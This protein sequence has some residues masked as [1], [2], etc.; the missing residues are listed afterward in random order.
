MRSRPLLHDLHR[1]RWVA[2]VWVCEGSLLFSGETVL[3]VDEKRFPCTTTWPREPCHHMFVLNGLVLGR[4]GA[5]SVADKS[6]AFLGV[7]PFF[8]GELAQKAILHCNSYVVIGV[9]PVGI[10]RV[11]LEVIVITFDLAFL[12]ESLR[13]HGAAGQVRVSHRH[14][15]VVEFS[16]HGEWPGVFLFTVSRVQAESFEGDSFGLDII[17]FVIGLAAAPE[18][19]DG[20]ARGLPP[21]IAPSEG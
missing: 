10:V 2:F 21:D 19:T 5:V 15:L 13:I 18:R 14:I 8:P 20:L 3:F 17:V 16:R 1:R 12:E 9:A 4:G 11:G 7:V 6:V